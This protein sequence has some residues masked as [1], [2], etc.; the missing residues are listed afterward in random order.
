M[1][2]LHFEEYVCAVYGVGNLADVNEARLHLF[3]KLYAP[4]TQTD[5]LD[6]NLVQMDMAAGKSEARELY[7]TSYMS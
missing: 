2:L 5:Q 4:K 3:Q 6:K 7:L 1:G